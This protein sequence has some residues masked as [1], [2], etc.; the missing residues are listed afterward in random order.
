MLYNFRGMVQDISVVYF[1]R[2][3]IMLPGKGLAKKMV[4]EKLFNNDWRVFF[5]SQMNLHCSQAHFEI[6]NRGESPKTFW[7]TL[8]AH[9]VV[10]V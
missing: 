3:K 6:Y 5:Y 1:I 9:K 4:E 2:L 7:D 8:P 10:N